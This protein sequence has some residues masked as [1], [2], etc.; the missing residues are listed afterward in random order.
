MNYV[1]VLEKIRHF[2]NTYNIQ[3]L[4]ENKCDN[5][6]HKSLHLYKELVNNIF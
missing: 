2:S 6:G 5:S 4:I 3:F 1:W